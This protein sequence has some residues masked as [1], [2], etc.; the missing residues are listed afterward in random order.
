MPMHGM[1]VAFLCSADSFRGSAV[2]LMHLAQGLGGRHGVVRV[3]T[4]CDDVAGPLHAEGVDVQQ[5]DL[6]A[7]NWRTGKALRRALAAFGAEVLIVDRPRDLRLGLLATVGSKVALV[8]RYNSHAAHPPRDLLTR[9]AY[10]F[11]VR[12]TIFLT[13]EKAKRI[14]AKAPWMH[15][16]SHHVIPEGVCDTQFRPDTE[17]A[18]Q[19]RTRYQL[20]DAPFLLTVGALTREKRADFLIDA[21]RDIPHA[22]TLVFCGVGPLQE[23]LAAQ[24]EL[25]DV[26]VR[27][28]GQVPRE[29]LR[30]AYS[31]ASVLVHACEVET[32]GLSVLEAMA[33]GCP[34]VGVN[35]GGLVE[36]VG[37]DGLAG[38]LVDA[39]APEEMAQAVMRL[40]S[41]TELTQRVRLAARERAQSRFSLA[42]MSEGYER[43]VLGA[44]LLASLY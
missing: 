4:G 6:S 12:Q 24:A 14:L 41:D 40:L 7:T 5:M 15:R 11:G 36:V 25:L 39:L 35:A 2:S 19:F 44:W 27:F 3:F 43:A 21:V 17:A 9:L 23:S 33:C 16:A 28:L 31:A 1:R 34:V 42:R 18:A 10:R 20:G 8:N 38:L 30:G 22:P 37:T 29:E 13:H 32:F 26:K